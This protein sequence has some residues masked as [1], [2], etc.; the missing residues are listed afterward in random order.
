MVDIKLLLEWLGPDGSLAGLEQSELTVSELREIAESSSLSLPSKFTRSQIIR[1]IV[2]ANDRRIEK[3]GDEL[4]DMS[5]EA[6]REYLGSARPS[7]RE[8]LRLL[9]DFD[10]RPPSRGAGNLLDFVAREIGDI[11]MYQRVAK[12]HSGDSRE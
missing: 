7:K 11:G 2:D 8:L 5:Y 9:A 10:V 3:S 12:G 6:L 4:R 1:S